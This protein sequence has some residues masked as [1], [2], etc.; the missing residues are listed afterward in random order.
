M[1]GEHV[2][3][4]ASPTELKE[5]SLPPLGRLLRHEFHHLRPNWGWF[6]ALGL[7]LVVCGT[8][9]IAGPLFATAIAI[10]FLAAVLLVAGVATIVTAFRPAGGA[11]SWCSCCLACFMWWPAL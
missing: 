9:A 7:L 10:E 11:A 3:A 5:E 8:L 6:L 2:S 4:P 1:N